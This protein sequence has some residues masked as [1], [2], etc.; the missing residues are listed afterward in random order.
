MVTMVSSG[1]GRMASIR[2]TRAAEQPWMSPMAMVRAGVMGMASSG[3]AERL[4]EPA[5]HLTQAGGEGLVDPAAGRL[6]GA[7]PPGG[8]GEDRVPGGAAPRGAPAIIRGGGGAGQAGV[9]AA[10]PADGDGPTD[11]VLEVLRLQEC[12]DRWRHAPPA[13]YVEL[14]GLPDP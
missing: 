8:V 2:A 4:G 3:A 13:G 1:W 12:P 14:V 9:R 11:G 6:R 7:P 10:A 5:G